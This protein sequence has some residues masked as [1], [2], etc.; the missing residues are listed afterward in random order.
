MII[1]FTQTVCIRTHSLHESI[2]DVRNQTL[3]NHTHTYIRLNY[4][5]QLNTSIVFFVVLFF[6]MSVVCVYVD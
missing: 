5:N 1:H 2:G 6:K 3:M 4:T